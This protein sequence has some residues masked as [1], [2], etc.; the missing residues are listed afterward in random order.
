MRSVEDE[1]EEGEELEVMC[2]GRDAR[3]HVKVSRKALLAPQGTPSG[4][5]GLPPSP[6]QA[7]PPPEHPPTS[8]AV[9]SSPTLNISCM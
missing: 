8:M 4:S 3:G 6:A 1:L 2:Q 9:W 5:P 7:H